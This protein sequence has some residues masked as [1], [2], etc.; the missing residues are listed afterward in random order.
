MMGEVGRELLA[1]APVPVKDPMFVVPGSET[2]PQLE[3]AP[4]GPA[5]VPQVP[6]DAP[7]DPA[8]MA[9]GKTGFTLCMACHGPDGEGLPTLAPPLAGSEWVAGPVENLIRIQ[10]RGLTGPITVKGR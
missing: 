9:K 5:L 3:K 10:L 1:G 4:G 6:A 7:V 8:V 2:A